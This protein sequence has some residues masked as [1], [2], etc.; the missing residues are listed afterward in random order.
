MNKNQ[1]LK[2]LATTTVFFSVI[3]AAIYY[4]AYWKPVRSGKHPITE[5]EIG[6]FAIIALV[7]SACHLGVSFAQSSVDIGI[8]FFMVSG[9]VH[10][11]KVAA[12]I[13]FYKANKTSNEHDN[14][15]AVAPN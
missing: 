3:P 14:E 7:A 5:N 13:L 15:V 1:R 10:A 9:F 2:L 8:A 12:L 6:M 11:T 4:L